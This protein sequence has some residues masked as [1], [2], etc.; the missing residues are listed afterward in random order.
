MKFLNRL[1]VRQKLLVAM[2]FAI[3]C[4]VFVSTGLSVALT[5]NS[6]KQ[7][8]VAVELPAALGE[9]RNDVLRQI[10]A[11]LALAEGMASNTYLLDWEAK[12]LPDDGIDAWKHY[13]QALKGQANAS[14][15]SW[16]SAETGK[17]LNETGLSRTVSRSD[18]GD[19]WL[20]KFL[21]S[22]KPYEL[23]LDKD[24]ASSQYNLFINSRFD[25]G[26]KVGVASLG[27]SISQL[28]D[29]IR[30]YR[31]GEH[32]FVYLVRPDGAYVIHRNTM[33]ADGHHFLKDQ[34][35]FD[36]QSVATLLSNQKFAITSVDGAN[37]KNFVAASY[38]PELN[39][40]V[41]AEVP[42]ADVLGKITQTSTI[43]AIVAS[44][45]G[46][47]I[48][49]LIIIVVC[50]TI[51][52][53][54]GRAALMLRDIANGNGDLTRRMKV[55][56]SDE[57]GVLA[58]S[59][60]RFVESLNRIIAE[61]RTST[62]TITTVSGEIA[63]G[64]LDLSARTESQASSLQ[65]TAAA[66]EELTT[67][68]QQNATNARAANDLVAAAVGC[69]Q[70]GGD[71]VANVVTSMAAI[72]ESSRR[73]TEI[74]AVIDGIAFQTNILSLN[75]AVEAARAGEQGR[76]FAVV[77]SEVRSLAQRSASA[78]KEIKNLIDG[79]ALNVDEGSR[80]VAI[81]KTSMTEIVASV[82]RVTHIISEIANASAEQSV[83]I[84][85]VNQAVVLIDQN[86]QRNA[87]QVE[88]A[89]AAAGA[90]QDQATALARIVAMF[91]LDEHMS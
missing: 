1:S 52:G 27:L 86:T 71:V 76:G 67:T 32:G 58:Q 66:M 72:S 87:A 15:I 74:I 59:F 13:A 47:G 50:Q 21:S 36:G 5:G 10:G 33:L 41:L 55:E 22:G 16:V 77:A 6:L 91:K 4:F 48:G 11:P 23:D 69:A 20:Y 34:P 65:E 38:M 62:Q 37:G 30:S 44:L 70:R 40:Y 82:E 51:V 89:A 24:K 61:V 73:I 88:E 12:G 29:A 90:M 78:A 80:Q 81:A 79:S 54:L 42:E 46:G 45:V 3:L 63:S 56:S 25:A 64:N 83:G 68:V 28:A 19:Q 26:G 9:I 57:V 2:G 53:P 35:G 17:Y 75:A 43:A 31:I 8:A 39:L 60:N 84:G 7:R 18:A 49:L 14:T 85:Q